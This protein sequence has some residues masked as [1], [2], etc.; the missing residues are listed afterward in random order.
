M[1]TYDP[2]RWKEW[3]AG[4]VA[5]MLLLPF[6]WPEPTL[7]AAVL[8]L[9]AIA[10]VGCVTALW[11]TFGPRA[12]YDLDALK[13]IDD[14]AKL[15][16]LSEESSASDAE[17]VLCIGCGQVFESEYSVCPHCRRPAG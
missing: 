7:S 4:L 5:G 1:P 14:R 2:N 17:Q 10:L 16:T 9:S 13:E 8:F 11:K 6:V 3:T 15:Q 12:R